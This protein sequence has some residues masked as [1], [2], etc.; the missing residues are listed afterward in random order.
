MPPKTK[1]IINPHENKIALFTDILPHH[2]VATQ[3][4]NFI[5]VGTAINDVAIVK[6]NLIQGGVPLVNMWWAQ[7]TKPSTTIPIIEKTIVVYPKS[8]FLECTGSI[9][10]TKPK[11]G[12]TIM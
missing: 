3:L 8:G 2:K 5:P 10:L 12:R 11:A 6:N 1:F 4:K 9:S 7:T